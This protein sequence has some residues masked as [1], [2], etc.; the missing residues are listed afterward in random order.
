[1]QQIQRALCVPELLARDLQIPH[2]GHDGFVPHK[3]LDG[4]RISPGLQQ[5]CGEGVAQRMDPA[6]FVDAGILWTSS[7]TR[8]PAL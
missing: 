3:E 4:A 5:M 1:M 6:D 2:G 8:S 7:L